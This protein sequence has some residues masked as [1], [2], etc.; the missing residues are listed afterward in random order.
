MD[1]TPGGGVGR[2]NVG[3]RLS[4]SAGLALLIATLVFV[5]PAQASSIFFLRS[6]NIWVAN[7]DGSDASR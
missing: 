6:D 2:A 7:P 1:A 5:A 4:A 3:G